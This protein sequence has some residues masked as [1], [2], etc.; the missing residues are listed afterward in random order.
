MS[1]GYC[2]PAEL[3]K[4]APSS[5]TVKSSS[6][7]LLNQ[8]AFE[9]T[10]T[11][12][13][14]SVE[15]RNPEPF[16]LQAFSEQIITVPPSL[17]EKPSRKMSYDVYP[18]FNKDK[19]VMK[20]EIDFSLQNCGKAGNVQ[21]MKMEL[22]SS[23]NAISKSKDNIEEIFNNNKLSKEEFVK[24]PWK[25]LNNNNLSI[26]YQDHIYTWKVIAPIIMAQ[27]AFGEELPNDTLNSLTQ[28]QQG[29]L[30]WRK[31]NQDA[32][33]INLKKKNIESPLPIEKAQQ[34]VVKEI[35]RRQSVQYK[36][37]SI[38]STEQIKMLNLK[39][40]KND[41]SFEVSS[42]YQGTQSLSCEIY[43]WEHDDKIVISDLDGT[44]TKS[45]VLG[46]IFP[47]IGK[48]WSHNNVV[49]LY[50]D[51]EKNGFKILYLTARAI[52]QF[53]TTKNYLRQ[54]KQSK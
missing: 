44:I 43:L 5:P 34:V 21:N 30:F 12:T 50:T 11:S 19:F 49:K 33:K 32:Y 37:S 54:L 7:A 16:Q 6:P 53:D 8:M 23:W 1:D 47:L 18:F 48:D 9:G 17:I 40:G 41:I 45:D 10:S 29:H 14:P 25:Y 26:R 24:D 39:P 52:G 20:K 51:I 22:S 36:K 31:I 42:K 35:V 46:H 28:Q 13:S 15:T 27:L 3:G 4:S 2:S 38:I